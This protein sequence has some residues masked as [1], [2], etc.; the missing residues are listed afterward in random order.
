MKMIKMYSLVFMAFLMANN[1][2]YAQDAAGEMAPKEKWS[3]I[4]MEGKVTEINKETRD[5][6]LMTSEGGLSTFTADEAIERFDEI[7]VNDVISFD[8]WTYILAE[9]RAPTEEELA[10]P[11]LIIAEAGKAPEG[12]DPAA[13][14][15]AIV[16]AVVTIEALN[17]PYMM[18]VLKGPGGNYI[19]ID[20]E[21]VTIFPKL[22]IGQVFILTYAE[23]MVVSLNK[24]GEDQ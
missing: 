5:I 22:H 11:I 19:T 20:V 18:A 15:G 23:A 12:V 21:D 3:L 2:A 8:Y 24:P 7:E 1:V 6:T 14:V 9:F 16:R 17:R 10:E 4:T 13:A